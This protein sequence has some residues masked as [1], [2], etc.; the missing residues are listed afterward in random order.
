[1]NEKERKTISKFLSYVLR[2]RPDE[3]GVELDV[4][5]WIDVER[6]LAAAGANGRPLSHAQLDEVVATNDK[7]RFAFSDDGQQ[8]RASQGHSVDVDLGYEP[9]APPEI[10]FH[11][12]VP[13]FLPGIKAEGLMRGKRTHVHLSATEETAITVGKRRGKPVVLTVAAQDMHQDGFTFFLTP[14]QVWLTVT[15]P[16]KFITGWPE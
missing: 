4:N 8:I 14:N 5:G 9:A 2:H 16:S 3:I 6:L 11:G 7:Q 1:M 15:V 13:A 10:L 12:T